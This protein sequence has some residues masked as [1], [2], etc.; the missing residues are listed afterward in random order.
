MSLE[1]RPAF[2]TLSLTILELASWL[3]KHYNRHYMKPYMKQSITID[4][5][6]QLS[7]TGRSRLAQWCQEHYPDDWLM[8]GGIQLLNIGQMIELLGDGWIAAIRKEAGHTWG[9]PRKERLC[10][11]L[12]EAVKQKLERDT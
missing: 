2:A 8:P 5:I 4:D 9:I 6:N 7:E 12:W 3:Q 1:K 11:G 10:D